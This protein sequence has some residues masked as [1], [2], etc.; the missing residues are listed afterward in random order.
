MRK[1]QQREPEPLGDP[2][3]GVL[4][5]DRALLT[6]KEVTRAL[7]VS[8]R[9]LCYWTASRRGR[10]PLLPSVKLGKCRRY[11]VADV[12]RLIEEFTQKTG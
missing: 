4:P 11:V 3:I 5:A 6:A 12:L 10:R 1:R 7:K 2:R 8:P 9:T